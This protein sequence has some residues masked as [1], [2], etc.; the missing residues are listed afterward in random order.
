MHRF[1]FCFG[2]NWSPRGAEPQGSGG[3][4]DLHPPRPGQHGSSPTLWEQNHYRLHCLWGHVR[5][6][7]LGAA[8][9]RATFSASQQVSCVFRSAGRTISFQVLG[10]SESVC[11]LQT[12]RISGRSLREAGRST[13]WPRT[14]RP[15]VRVSWTPATPTPR[16]T[17]GTRTHRRRETGLPRWLLTGPLHDLWKQPESVHPRGHG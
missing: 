12:D 4:R 11:R 17:P 9:L 13:R 6:V 2:E 15:P 1:C 3:R 8:P 16:P 14:P 10:P 7:Y 5:P